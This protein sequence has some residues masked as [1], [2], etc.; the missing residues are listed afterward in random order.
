MTTTDDGLAPGDYAYGVAARTATWDGSAWTGATQDA[1]AT[2]APEAWRRAFLPFLRHRWFWMAVAGFAIAAVPAWIASAGSTPIAQP[3]VLL[4]ALLL[5]VS[6]AV[7][8]MQHMAPTGID[9]MRLVVIWGVASGLVGFGLAWLIEAQWLGSFANQYVLLWQAGLTEETCKLLVPVLLLAFGGATFR[10]PITGLFLV[11]LSGAVF[12]ALELVDYA[13][14]TSGNGVIA[15]V[16]ERASA[17]LLHPFITAFAAALIW[18]G[19]WR[20]KKTLTTVGVVGWLIAIALH[21]GH[22]GIQ[23]LLSSNVTENDTRAFTSMGEAVAAGVLGLAFN[24]LV[25]M[26]FFYVMR[27]TARELTPPG[28][29]SRNAPHWRPRIKQWGV[30]RQP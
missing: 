29:V 21:S 11:L 4:G 9:S 17:E 18:L 23:S 24:A 28:S 19:A 5:M 16:L 22:D 1:P 25:S 8:V 2:P 27:Y 15:T 26:V 3:V 12:G 7:L 30:V 14:N 20:R 13:V 6:F 10:A